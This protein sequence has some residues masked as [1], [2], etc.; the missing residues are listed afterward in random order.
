MNKEAKQFNLYDRQIIELKDSEARKVIENIN[1]NLEVIE[2]TVSNNARNIAEHGEKINTIETNINTINSNIDTINDTLTTHQNSI[3]S[4]TN[5][6]ST[7][8]SKVDD[9]VSDIHEML[10]DDT[11]LINNNKDNIEKLETKIKNISNLELS[12]D[13]TNEKITIASKEA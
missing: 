6:I 3:E 2:S 1:S 8:S 4:N 7:L 5:A 13:S 10:A 12:Y 9:E 11:I